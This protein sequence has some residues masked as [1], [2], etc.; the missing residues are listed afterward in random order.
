MAARFATLDD[1]A[2]PG[3]FAHELPR[4]SAV[5]A[6]AKLPKFVLDFHSQEAEAESGES[7]DD[8]TGTHEH[9]EDE[10]ELPDDGYSIE[11]RR[12]KG[13]GVQ[14]MLVHEELGR[15]VF[16]GPPDKGGQWEIYSDG[17]GMDYL[18]QGEAL[19]DVHEPELC[20]NIFNEIEDAEASAKIGQSLPARA[21]KPTLAGDQNPG[22]SAAPG[23][24][25]KPKTPKGPQST[26]ADD[27]FGGSD[28]GPEDDDE[29][30]V[31]PMKPLAPLV[32][33]PHGGIG[34]QWLLHPSELRELALPGPDKPPEGSAHWS[35]FEDIDAETGAVLYMLQAAEPHLKMRSCDVLLAS[36]KS[37][38][39][40]DKDRKEACQ[41]AKAEYEAELKRRAE[42]EQ[43]IQQKRAAKEAE[44]RLAQE[45]EEEERIRQNPAA[46]A[47]ARAVAES[48]LQEM[49]QKKM[50]EE[51]E[52]VKQA[53]EAR[54][55]REAKKREAEAA[56]RKRAEAEEQ[57]KEK[58]EAS[59]LAAPEAEEQAKEKE[60]AEEAS[61]RAAAEAEKQ[62][63]EKEEAAKRAAAEIA[64]T[65]K[66]V[67]DGKPKRKEDEDG[68]VN[69]GKRGA[70]NTGAGSASDKR[71]K[72]TALSPELVIKKVFAEELNGS[73]PWR[74]GVK[75]ILESSVILKVVN[76]ILLM[77][78]G[79]DLASFA[80]PKRELL[81]PGKQ[82]LSTEM[83]ILK[84]VGD[85]EGV[86]HK[87]FNYAWERLHLRGFSESEASHPA[88]NAFKKAMTA[89][90]LTMPIMKLS[91]ICNFDHGAWKSGDKLEAK[92]DAFQAY[93]E[94]QLLIS[95]QC[96]DY[97]EAFAERVAAD[98]GEA[99]DEQLD[100]AEC[101][102]EWLS[103]RALRN[104]GLYREQVEETEDE[105]EEGDKEPQPEPKNK[106]EL[107]QI[108]NKDGPT[109]MIA[110]FMS[111]AYLQQVARLIVVISSPLENAYYK[112]LEAAAEGWHA[113]AS[114]AASRSLGQYVDTVHD[115]LA[116]LGGQKLHDALQ[117]TKP[118]RRPRPE[119]MPAWALKELELLSTCSSFASS[120]ASNV[121]W[122]NAHF[123]MSMPALLSTV[124][125]KD[126]ARRAEAMHHAK[127]LVTAVVEAE[128]HDC[129]DVAWSAMLA[130]LGWHRQQFARETMALFLQSGFN[131]RDTS[132]RKLAKRLYLGSFTTK[133]LLESCFAFLHR[134]A[135]TH[136]TNF[137]MS[138]SCKWL[139]AIVSPYAEAGGCPQVLP[140]KSD[141]DTVLGPTGQCDREYANQNM[142]SIKKTELPNPETMH[143]P[144]QMKESKWK[145]S[146]PL[147]QQ[148]SS[149][150]A[151]YLMRD[152][153]SRWSHIDLCWVGA[154][155][156]Q[157]AVFK[158]SD[159]G[160]EEYV[161]SMGFRKWAA[162]GFP[163][164]RVTIQNQAIV[165]MTCFQLRDGPWKLIP[166]ELALRAFAPPELLSKGL[167]SAWRIVDEE[168]MPL[169][170][171]GLRAGVFLTVP[172]LK[173][174]CAALGI[175]M[176]TKG[177]GKKGRVLK[178]DIA[179]KMCSELFPDDDAETRNKMVGAI[180]FRSGKH[181]TEDEQSVLDC[182]A[183]LAE[184]D[185]E[186]PEFKKLAH[187]A[188][189]TLHERIRKR[190][191]K[192]SKES[193]FVRS[194]QVFRFD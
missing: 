52:S 186:C 13:K 35:I 24:K 58:E 185:R 178:A 167:C 45:R 23:A 75:G 46:M 105:A 21:V 65:K 146:G 48:M 113:Q 6:P 111:D 151:A 133:D 60:E 26:V 2:D 110:G 140:E 92:K 55:L 139:Y 132:L 51:A 143:R 130:D 74:Q 57:A 166:T 9:V 47:A 41:V 171:G 53:D 11:T 18:W 42:L 112:A 177:S 73:S 123:W 120:L 142:F 138:D 68:K 141:F 122:S 191:V 56:A 131:C 127:L 32:W 15:Q 162:A 144:K 28:S 64:D 14:H 66:T 115:I 99:F 107:Y 20:V 104:R 190:A 173:Q 192:E 153:E 25:S 158:R 103:T 16:L 165:W 183:Q 118:S 126:S 134:K 29:T 117:V 124:L 54:A 85:D 89:S 5:G 125:S 87:A 193:R 149:A 50:Q 63:K 70:E 80:V 148:R 189:N 147:A 128:R 108:F 94:D 37:K 188:K 170:E 137:K 194:V 67:G 8:G 172:D 1:N 116:T 97:Y 159:G 135:A 88:W 79:K 155:F 81:V 121:F 49:I 4:C 157:G 34:K 44:A 12:M 175:D 152:R 76:H 102:A 31:P 181:L 77:M 90:N 36:R 100:A 10:E 109:S 174:L 156:K 106:T 43:K 17:S 27:E 161:L 7:D 3:P 71:G 59:K 38:P 98:R 84:L 83:R 176:P 33:T 169:L 160:N 168:G 101:M 95:D 91:L 62:A 187:L 136:S 30:S 86:Q 39:I 78:T 96:E 184:E 180:C 182:V 129:S 19:K 150:A 69:E 119:E 163:L 179:H 22:G 114:F 93:L 145:N 154:F 40:V 61:K 82:D 164:E 72:K